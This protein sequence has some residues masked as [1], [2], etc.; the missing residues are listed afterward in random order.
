MNIIET[1]EIS[2]EK[3]QLLKKLTIAVYAC[4]VFAVMMIGVPL[5]IGV[6]INFYK[7]REV[8]GTWLESHFEWQ[9]KTAW[10]SLAGFALAG[11]TFEAGVGFYILLVTV[12]WLIYRITIGWYSL[13]DGKPVNDR[14][15]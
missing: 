12:V 6:A 2:A 9:I 8:Q 1:E 4:Q 15:V 11:L 3:M 5:L 14:K 7:R 10:L 13:N